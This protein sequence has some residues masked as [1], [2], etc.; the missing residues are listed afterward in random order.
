MTGIMHPEPLYTVPSWLLKKV[1]FR[2]ILNWPANG[3]IKIGSVTHDADPL[4]A[5][6]FDV[7]IP[8]EALRTGPSPKSK[9]VDRVKDV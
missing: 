7:E 3:S 1:P 8:E 2:S 4:G 9:D 5:Y 6:Y